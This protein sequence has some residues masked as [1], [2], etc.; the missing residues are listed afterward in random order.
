[1]SQEI[2]A[3]FRANR[4]KKQANSAPEIWYRSLGRLS[5]QCFEFAEELLNWIEISTV[6]RQP[7]DQNTIFEQ[8][9]SGLCT[10]AAI[11]AEIPVGSPRGH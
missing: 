6:W 8:A 1:M 5:Q 2:G 10:T 4:A 11:G 9:Q 7:K 3:L